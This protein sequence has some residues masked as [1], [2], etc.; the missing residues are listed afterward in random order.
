MFQKTPG[1][2]DLVADHQRWLILCSWSR[3]GAYKFFTVSI[4]NCFSESLKVAF[5]Y[6]TSLLYTMVP[7]V[8]ATAARPEGTAVTQRCKASSPSPMFCKS[9]VSKMFY[10]KI[11][12]SE[13]P[14]KKGQKLDKCTCIFCKE[15]CI[16][17][18]EYD[19]FTACWV[20]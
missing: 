11:C 13:F 12:L 17:V 1:Y 4:A 8:L 5:S 15:V 7:A 3:S 19:T 18:Y 6:I 20:Y 9:K 10:C 14:N 16:H 2:F